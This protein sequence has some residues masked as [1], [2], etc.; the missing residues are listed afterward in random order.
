M[1][2]AVLAVLAVQAIP[3]PPIISDYLPGPWLVSVEP[4][5]VIFQAC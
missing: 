3:P 4:R 1:I 5:S 2:A